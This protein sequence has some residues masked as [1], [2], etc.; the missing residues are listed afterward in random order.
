MAKGQ[1]KVLSDAE[2]AKRDAAKRVK[3]V[4]LAQK[5]TERALKA[6][7]Q[8]EHLGS[9]NYIRT[10]VQSEAIVV[11]LSDAVKSVAQVLLKG[12]TERPSFKLPA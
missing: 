2:K 3:F 4:E 5:R 10:D 7:R 1:K 11:A 12:I 6:I 8:I 9:A